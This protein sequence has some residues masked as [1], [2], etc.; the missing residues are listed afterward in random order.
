MQTYT[1]M[2][3]STKCVL[4]LVMAHVHRIY[5]VGLLGVILLSR[6]NEWIETLKCAVC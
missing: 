2:Q 3:C 4:I 6:M 5:Y 1:A